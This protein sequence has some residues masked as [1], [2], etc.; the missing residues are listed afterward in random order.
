MALE[1]VKSEKSEESNA[2]VQ[3]GKANGVDNRSKQSSQLSTLIA[4]TCDPYRAWETH[5]EVDYINANNGSLYLHGQRSSNRLHSALV[6][7]T[8]VNVQPA[9]DVT[10]F[11][12]A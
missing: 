3:D 10:I 5:G 1:G 4:E 9:T 12:M 7:P 8:R 2:N 6:L 11:L